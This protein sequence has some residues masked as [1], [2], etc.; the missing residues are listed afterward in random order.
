VVD[1]HQY[2]VCDALAGAADLLNVF[3]DGYRNDL[4]VVIS[5]FFL[6]CL[7]TWQI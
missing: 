4:E 3:V 2:W 1:I 7:P 5:E 6:E